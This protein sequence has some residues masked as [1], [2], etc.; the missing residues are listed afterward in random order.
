VLP[1]ARRHS[2]SFYWRARLKM[3]LLKRWKTPSSISSH[4]IDV[5]YRARHIDFLSRWLS[6]MKLHIVVLSIT[7]Q[8]CSMFGKEEEKE[9]G[10]TKFV[11]VCLPFV[12]TID[13]LVKRT[14]SKKKSYFLHSINV[15]HLRTNSFD[16]DRCKYSWMLSVSVIFLDWQWILKMPSIS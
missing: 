10:K 14:S 15:R 8:M 12:E 4:M 13:F 6:A 7:N 3:S 2:S 11:D 1:L 16:S 5:E 9:E